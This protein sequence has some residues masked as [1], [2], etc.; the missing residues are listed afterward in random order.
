MNMW[1]DTFSPHFLFYWQNFMKYATII[2]HLL[3]FIQEPDPAIL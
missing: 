2:F 1:M 3:Y